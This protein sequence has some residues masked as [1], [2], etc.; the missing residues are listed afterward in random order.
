MIKDVPHKS[1]YQRCINGKAQHYR[2]L[3]G[4]SLHD[5]IEQ[6]FDTAKEVAELALKGVKPE[7]EK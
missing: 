3:M 2:P 7:E 5:S 6:H 1:A 4:Y